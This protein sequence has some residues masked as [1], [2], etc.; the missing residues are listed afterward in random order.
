MMHNNDSAFTA[1]TPTAPRTE[2]SYF[3]MQ[4]LSGMHK[5]VADFRPICGMNAVNIFQIKRALIAGTTTYAPLDST[6]TTQLRI[7]NDSLYYSRTKIVDNICGRWHNMHVTHNVTSRVVKVWIDGLLEFTEHDVIRQPYAYYFKAG[8]YLN[9]GDSPYRYLNEVFY[10]NIAMY[11]CTAKHCAD[12]FVPTAAPTAWPTAAPT[13]KTLVATTGGSSIYVGAGVGLL[14]LLG[15]SFG[16][17]YHYRYRQSKHQLL[18]KTKATTDQRSLYKAFL[19]HAMPSSS[20]T[21]YSTSSPTSSSVSS[22]GYDEAR[23]KGDLEDV[24]SKV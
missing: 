1:T 11:N 10:K 16:A 23:Q 20:S 22:A 21:S 2:L 13:L 24:S 14:L 19:L 18:A 12:D 8:V 17:A 7:Y 5:F 6:V 9:S 3:P 4:Y 15:S